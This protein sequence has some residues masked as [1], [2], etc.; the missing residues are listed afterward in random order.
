MIVDVL[1]PSALFLVGVI[2]VF[3]YS[4]I[5]KKVDRLVGGQ[6]LHLK[7]VIPL[8][9]GIGIMVTITLFIPEYALLGLFLFAYIAILFLLSSAEFFFTCISISLLINS[10]IYLIIYC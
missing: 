7:H 6:E 3:L 10:L 9:L 4:R 8:V 1:L 5:D 2:V